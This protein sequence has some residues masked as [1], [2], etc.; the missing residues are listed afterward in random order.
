MWSSADAQVLSGGTDQEREG[1][2]LRTS[3]VPR[4]VEELP[5]SSRPR[6]RLWTQPGDPTPASQRAV[7]SARKRSSHSSRD[8]ADY[9]YLPLATFFQGPFCV[10]CLFPSNELYVLPSLNLG[11]ILLLHLPHPAKP[12]CC[13]EEMRGVV[14]RKYVGVDGIKEKGETSSLLPMSLSSLSLSLFKI[15]G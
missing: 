1:Q 3:P 5:L 2:A 8:K 14:T 13:L 11:L 4:C 6:S 7:L 9:H 15:H 12:R 10:A